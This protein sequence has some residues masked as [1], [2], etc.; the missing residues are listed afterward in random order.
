MNTKTYY[1]DFL[2]KIRE[3]YSSG[4]ALIITDRIFEHFAGITK[5]GLLKDPDQQLSNQTIKQLD[6]ALKQLLQHK[7]MQ[8]VIGEAWF[9][10]LK[11]KVNGAVL[12]PRPETEELVD[13]VIKE[14]KLVAPFILDIGT[15]SGC[16]PIAI[17][18]N[19]PSANVF[20]MDVSEA[21][22][23]VAKE[24]AS[25]NETAINFI[26]RDLLNEMNWPYLPKVDII[27]S[28]PPY[29]PENE[30]EK[31]EKNVV[32]HEP[33]LALFVPDKDPLLFY[34]AIAA[35]GRTHLNSNGKI[36]L[37][38]HESLAENARTLFLG[39][40]K[41]AELKKDMFGRDRIIIVT[42]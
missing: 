1:R 6:N 19:I 37:E 16:I 41:T 36:Y 27:V 21:A 30:K 31:L 24:N 8:Y 12:I 26:Q 3:I 39:S 23:H 4:E 9:Y 17:K 32:D 15:G 14:N 5:A 42:A 13:L 29:I 35:L 11:F 2:D 20:T 34:A 7:P 38:A 10:K 18:K 28:N 22:L 33:H 25:M 40:Y